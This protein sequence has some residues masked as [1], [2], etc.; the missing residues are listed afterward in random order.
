MIITIDGPVASGKSSVAR[1]LAQKINFYYLYTGLLYRSLAYV[2]VR[3]LNY[4]LESLSAVTS[5]DMKSI[6]SPHVYEYRYTVSHGAEIWYKGENLTSYLKLAEVDRMASIIS[7]QLHVREC[8]LLLQRYIGAQHN[9]I[10][11]GRDC[12]TVVFP[13]AEYKFFLTASLEMRAKR[14]QSD[15]AKQGKVFSFE[16]AL[17]KVAERD[18]RDSERQHSPLI[19]A[20]DAIIVDNSHFSLQETCDVLFEY[21]NK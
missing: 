20:H 17:E 7:A 2:A 11:D 3:D 14:W 18:K 8:V 13:Y 16:E 4:T 15:Q 12:G 10:A 1:L 6:F 19:P 21:I 5:H 9:I